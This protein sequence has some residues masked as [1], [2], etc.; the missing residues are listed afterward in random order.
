[1]NKT[2]HPVFINVINTAPEYDDPG[3]GLSFR[4]MGLT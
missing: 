1:M 3:E 4:D 2:H